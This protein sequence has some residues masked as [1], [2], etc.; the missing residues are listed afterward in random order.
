MDLNKKRIL[1]IG[2]V[3]PEPD[4]SAA[5]VRIMQLI[6]GFLDENY[7]VHFFCA[8]QKTEFSADLSS[9]GVF[10]EQIRLNHSS[11]NHQLEKV[12]PI[13]VVFDRFMTEEQF[14]WRVQEVCPTALR[15][16]DT[17]DLHFLRKSRQRANK[18]NRQI[19][20]DDYVSSGVKREVAS[21]LRCDIS[22][23]IS[24]VEMRLLQEELNVSSKLLYLLPM[25]SDEYKWDV[26]RENTKGFYDRKNM[27][28]IGNFLHDPNYDAV[29]FLKK[30]IWPSI[31]KELK[32]VELH[33]W[34]AYCGSKVMQLH[35]PKE[36]FFINGR[37]ANLE[38]VFGSAKVLI[39]P[40]R[41]GA[42]V[43]GKLI[44][45]MFNGV[46]SV[47]TSIGAESMCTSFSEWG[48][49]VADSIDELVK[50]SV[51]L[52]TNKERWEDSRL[53]GY[54]LLKKDYLTHDNSW[55]EDL[56]NI[57]LNLSKHRQD[58]FIG[59]LLSDEASQSLKFM[60]KWIELKNSQLD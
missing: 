19:N 4:S 18:E 25:W 36:G 42:G 10:T 40:L 28:F 6:K 16:L 23:I 20:F 17:E 35:Q 9:L 56:E 48:G 52:Y 55:I 49:V 29:L 3:W 26:Q 7:E 13:I 47:T 33:I 1:F 2:H 8:A 22:L 46:P 14:G 11:F 38:Q 45:A 31:R 41:F 27:V 34:G 50:A 43:K 12:E 30:N 54:H 39:A 60:S 15:V 32:D 53:K 51:E 37:A 24:S 5:G 58:N 57:R 21:I 59:M 44:D